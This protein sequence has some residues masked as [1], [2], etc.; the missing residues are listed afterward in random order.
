MKRKELE[1]LFNKILEAEGVETYPNGKDYKYSKIELPLEEIPEITP[2]EA[3]ENLI[4]DNCVRIQNI[5]PMKKG[6]FEIQLNGI[7][8][9]KD[10][11]SIYNPKYPGV[12]FSIEKVKAKIDPFEDRPCSFITVQ[13][14][15]FLDESFTLWY[16]QTFGRIPFVK[17]EKKLQK[18][19]KK[20]KQL[21]I[22]LHVLK[23]GDIISFSR[24]GY[25]NF[26]MRAI[27]QYP[28]YL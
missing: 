19:Y 27:T 15:Y 26:C 17:N 23:H 13:N 8:E 5:R 1:D 9:I 20:L 21:F 18:E 2:E 24:S 11:E 6:K 10:D 25:S 22:I 16:R 7:Y 12:T 4:L 14:D 28:V 3:L